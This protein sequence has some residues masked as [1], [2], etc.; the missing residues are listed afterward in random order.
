MQTATFVMAT[1][2]FV[3]SA[4]LLVVVVVGSKKVNDRVES[5]VDEVKN[6]AND[7]ITKFQAAL[8]DLKL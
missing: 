1:L 3:T 5:V 6:E 2:S 8:Q 7:R 4:T